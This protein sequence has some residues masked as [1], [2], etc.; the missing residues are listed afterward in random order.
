VDGG[1]EAEDSLDVAAKRTEE[2]R[3]FC[4]DSAPDTGTSAAILLCKYIQN[5]NY[6]NAKCTL[7][8]PYTHRTHSFVQNAASS[9]NG[10]QS[11]QV[12]AAKSLLFAQNPRSKIAGSCESFVFFLV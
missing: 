2:K 11:R 5:M 6:V 12:F 9:L 8:T 10:L 7:Y 1:L 3:R 4:A